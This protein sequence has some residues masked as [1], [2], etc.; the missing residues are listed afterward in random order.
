MPAGG[1]ERPPRS[2]VVRKTELVHNEPKG[3]GNSSR[4]LAAR[5][6]VKRTVRRLDSTGAWGRYHPAGKSQGGGGRRIKINERPIEDC[7]LNNGPCQSWGRKDPGEP[8]GED[9]WEL[10][11][12]VCSNQKAGRKKKNQTTQH[13]HQATC[14]LLGRGAKRRVRDTPVWE[15]RVKKKRKKRMER[16]QR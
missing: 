9:K 10:P 6:S 4:P 12:K 13:L 15:Q 3:E 14:P 1:G 2:A 7:T 8:K 5:T 16:R 11:S